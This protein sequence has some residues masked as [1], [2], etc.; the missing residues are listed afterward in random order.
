MG[1]KYNPRIITNDLIYFLDAANT[2]CYSGSG[3]TAY[4]LTGD[5]VGT[6]TGSVGFGTT[7][8]GFFDFNDSDHISLG[9]PT[10]LQGLQLNMTLS[11]WFR[12][13]A[14]VTYGTLYSDYSGVSGH[15]LVSLL[16]VDSGLLFYFTST[17]NGNYQYVQPASI[18]TGVWNFVSV[19]VSGTSSSPVASIFLNGT[20]YTYN[21]S[22]IS[23]TPY[24]GSVHCIGG[25]VYNNETFNG[26]IAQVQ[27]YNRALTAQEISQN[28]NATKSRYV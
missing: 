8:Q 11:C 12:K 21:L 6:L 1:T 25:N 5:V 20:T 19:T 24:T 16:R 15:R 23:T 17:S 22:A 7:N 27:I 13:R 26:S 28:Y 10:I 9:N 14:N 2:R 4:S 3:N 18:A